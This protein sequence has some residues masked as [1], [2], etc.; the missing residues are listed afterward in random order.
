MKYKIKEQKNVS[1]INLE[2]NI[3]GGP[4]ALLLNELLHGLVKEGKKK[5]VLDMSAVKLMNSSGLGM[6][7]AALTTVRHASGNLKLAGVSKKIEN[8]FIITK[9][10]NIFEQYKTVKQAVDSY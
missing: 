9:L 10:I 8:L 4:D 5:I 7:I 1:V 3:M 6:L 2:G